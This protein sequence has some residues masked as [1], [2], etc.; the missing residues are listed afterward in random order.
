MTT[1]CKI[2][3][4]MTVI[5]K[6]TVSVGGFHATCMNCGAN[7]F[8]ESACTGCGTVFVFAA[9]EKMGPGVIDLILEYANN[10]GLE[11]IGYS[12]GGCVRL[13]GGDILNE[14]IYSIQ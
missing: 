14:D 5:S 8:G 4:P 7:Y 10:H 2:T 12:G 3:L 1:D 11:L 6:H 9:S 13:G